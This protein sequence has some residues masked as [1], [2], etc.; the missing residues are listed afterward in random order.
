MVRLVLDIITTRCRRAHHPRHCRRA[1]ITQSCGDGVQDPRAPFRFLDASQGENGHETQ[2][3][4]ARVDSLL[5]EG[6]FRGLVS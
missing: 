5:S 4:G 2:G 1:R 6:E 3:E